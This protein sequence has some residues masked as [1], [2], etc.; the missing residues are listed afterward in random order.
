MSPKCLL[1]VTVVACTLHLSS[2]S[3][4]LRFAALGAQADNVVDAFGG[5]KAELLRPISGIFGAKAALLR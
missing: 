3:P 1:L 5:F 2:P 4:T